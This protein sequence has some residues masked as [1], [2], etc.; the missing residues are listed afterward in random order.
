MSRKKKHEEHVNH[1][2]W[3]VSYAD[4]ITLLFAFFTTMYAIST[5]DAQKMGKMVMS[6]R[7]S[8]DSGLFTPGSDRMSL[9]PGSGDSRSTAKQ[10]LVQNIRVSNDT[11][12]GLTKGGAGGNAKGGEALG[13]LKRSVESLVGADALKRRVRTH[14]DSRGLVISLGEIGFFDSGSD[15]IKPEGLA[16]LDTIATGIS[17]TSNQI[18]VEGHTDNV[19]IRNS[20]FPSNWELSTSR[21][22]AV[23]AYLI[24]KFGFE[25]DRLSAAG[26]AEY[27]PAASNDTAEGRARNR[28]VD[29][30][31]L[32]ATSA[33]QEPR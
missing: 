31:V 4:F 23:V 8:F 29:I 1:E 12:A 22:T 10:D 33:Q 17:S 30:V 14:L 6:M 3:L 25:P 9:T 27:R 24:G 20:K 13:R 16:L 2:R 7:A 32:S 5:V 19:P 28:R 26:Y 18:R 15:I 11:S 21:A